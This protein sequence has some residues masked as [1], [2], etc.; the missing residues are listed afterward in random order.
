MKLMTPDSARSLTRRVPLF[1]T[2]ASLLMAPCLFAQTAAT[3]A[4]AATAPAGKSAPDASKLPSIHDGKLNI[5]FEGGLLSSLGDL[6]RTAFPNDNVV[7][8]ESAKRIELPGFELRN[9]SVREVGHTIEFLSEG[10]VRVE[11]EETE[12][13][14]IWRI[15]RNEPAAAAATV[16]MRSVP[17]PHLFADEKV[18][19]TIQ[20][21]AKEMEMLRL[22]LTGIIGGAHGVPRGAS[23]KPLSSQ[24]IFVIIGD[25]EGVAGLESLIAA[26]EQRAAEA[27]AAKVAALAANEMKMRAVLAPHVFSDETRWKKLT[28]EMTE[29]TLVWEDMSEHMRRE[30]GVETLSF[31]F[32]RVKANEKQ[33]VFVL[34]GSEAGIAGMGSLINAAE[35]L[36]AEEDAQVLA[37][38]NAERAAALKADE[39]RANA[40]KRAH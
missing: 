3:P 7:M 2:A 11:V 35:Q 16:K 23:A 18:I 30:T 34:F 40:D 27:T 19:E 36:A 5:Q 20:L 29:T 37:A 15:G 26:A 21:E 39:E 10:Q 9:V 32:A 24:K 33:K 4:Q 8:S 17:A 31:P 38:K 28:E 1:A 22:K 6:L 12:A 13:G 25:E 14:T